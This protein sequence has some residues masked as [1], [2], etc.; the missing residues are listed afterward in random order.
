MK[1]KSIEKSDADYPQCFAILFIQIW[2]RMEVLF[3]LGD[4]KWG[5]CVHGMQLMK[6]IR[7][8]HIGR[9]AD[10]DAKT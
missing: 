9:Y 2:I 3:P 10:E 7:G 5:F 4:N 1:F 8:H 6:S